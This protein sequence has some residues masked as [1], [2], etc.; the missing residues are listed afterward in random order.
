MTGREEITQEIGEAFDD[1]WAE[2]E[3]P[4]RVALRKQSPTANEFIDLLD[5]TDK[6]FFEY[7]ENRKRIVVE[8][9]DDS[10]S[11]QNAMAEATHIE[12]VNPNTDESHTYVITP[13]DTTPPFGTDFTWKLSG[14]LFAERGQFRPV[15]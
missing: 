7:S 8:I 13:A 5:L 14:N 10:A 9:A 4:I 2:F 3:T 6:V 1:A 11:V 15:Y 12:V